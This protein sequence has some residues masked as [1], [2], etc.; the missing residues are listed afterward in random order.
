MVGQEAEGQA[1]AEQQQQMDITGT[2]DRYGAEV[3]PGSAGEKRPT[4]KKPG[5]G[6]GASGTG[7]AR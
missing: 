6:G 7:G 5:S 4:K 3:R 2:G 1:T